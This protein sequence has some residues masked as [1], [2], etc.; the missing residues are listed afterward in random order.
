MPR[1]ASKTP[2]ARLAACSIVFSARISLSIWCSS[3]SETGSRFLGDRIRILSSGCLGL[4][5]SF[6]LALGPARAQGC[7]C[8]AGFFI[9]ASSIPTEG[10]LLPYPCPSTPSPTQ[11]SSLSSPPARAPKICFRFPSSRNFC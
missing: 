9:P 5:L 6:G 10:K 4:S 11:R 8:A 1:S 7:L 2:S 3:R